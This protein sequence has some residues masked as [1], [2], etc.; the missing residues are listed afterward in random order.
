MNPEERLQ[1]LLALGVPLE[2]AE[3]QVQIEFGTKSTAS[4][5]QETA[6]PTGAPG[7]PGFP[8][9][10]TG[11]PALFGAPPPR[12]VP[13]D[14][15]TDTTTDTQ[16]ETMGGVSP[17]LESLLAAISGDP[18]GGGA[19]PVTDPIGQDPFTG[20]VEDPLGLLRF[21]SEDQ[22]GRQQLF[23]ESLHTN[24]SY[25]SSPEHVR[26][27]LQS[28]FDPLEAQYV[29]QGLTDPRGGDDFRSYLAQNPQT[30]GGEDWSELFGIIN[31]L[32]SSVQSEGDLAD[33]GESP[34]GGPSAAAY[35]VLRSRGGDLLQTA[36]GANVHPALAQAARR[37]MARRLLE[38]G[39]AADGAPSN[40]AEFVRREVPRWQAVLG[41]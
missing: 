21:L 17:E 19:A 5:S 11:R 30:L 14:T 32:A 8:P 41:G 33:I 39:S 26:S 22:G 37:D 34:V 28:R 35:D 10:T 15:T 20:A 23:R 3:L 9:D 36:V 1:E 38:Y 13:A 25:S 27:F 12:D 6:E 7:V 24:P 18:S 29:A 2:L 16:L 40:Q 31:N 4:P